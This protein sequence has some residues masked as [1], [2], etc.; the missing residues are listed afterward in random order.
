MSYESLVFTDDVVEIPV[1]IGET[2]YLL[3]EASGGVATKYK[4]A[5]AKATKFKDG[6]VSSIDGINDAEPLLVSLCLFK[7]DGSPVNI[8]VV[9]LFKNSTQ[10]ALF[11]KA[12]EISNLSM[13]EDDT[14]KCSHEE[15]KTKHCPHCGEQVKEDE[16]G[17]VG[18]D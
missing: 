2:D 10:E 16:E 9:K 1:S 7:K 11:D 17:S 4:N 13:E 3:R 8:N 15:C 14:E 18:N 5:L 12:K 6:K